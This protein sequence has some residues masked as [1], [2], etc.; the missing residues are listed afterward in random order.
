MQ[1][2]SELVMPG[3]VPGIHVFV[4]VD[5]EETWMAG[6]SPA[7]TAF[8]LANPV[9]LKIQVPKSTQNCGSRATLRQ[10][11]DGAAQRSR[12]RPLPAAF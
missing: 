12:E 2:L 7:M 5:Q 4:P 1:P 11:R 9:P 3:L 8:N 6:S 10:F